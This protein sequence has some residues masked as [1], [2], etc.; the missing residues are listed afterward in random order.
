MGNP[1][2][3]RRYCGSRRCG[4]RRCRTVGRPFVAQEGREGAGIEVLLGVIPGAASTRSRPSTCRARREPGS[5]RA[6]R[7]GRSGSSRRASPGRRPDRVAVGVAPADALELRA[8]DP[9]RVAGPVTDPSLERTVNRYTPGSAMRTSSRTVTGPAAAGTV[10]I[11]RSVEHQ[12]VL[13]RAAAD[14]VL[15]PVLAA[16][17]EPE[18]LAGRHHR[19][20]DTVDIAGLGAPHDLEGG[21][22]RGQE[23]ALALEV[24]I[25]PSVTRSLDRACTGMPREPPERSP[26][27]I[28]TVSPLVR[29]SPDSRKATSLENR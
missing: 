23:H 8:P 24:D 22:V 27:V 2:R 29:G 11:G 19:W 13:G 20:C 16:D 6:R 1:T 9:D 4:G 3:C 5:R 26:T 15:E 25:E 21:P 18:G 12:P 28:V 17:R 10:R 14:R 7:R